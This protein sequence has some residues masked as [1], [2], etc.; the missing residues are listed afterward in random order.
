MAPVDFFFSKAVWQNRRGL[1]VKRLFLGFCC[2]G[3]FQ[4]ILF[5]LDAILRTCE[6]Q[7]L[8]YRMKLYEKVHV[9]FVLTNQDA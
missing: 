9:V 4:V 2:K 6:S 1:I 8:S 7:K 3:V 5:V